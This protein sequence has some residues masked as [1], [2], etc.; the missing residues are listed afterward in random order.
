MISVCGATLGPIAL[1]MAQD[2]FGSYNPM[3]LALALIPV[4]LAVVMALFL[5]DPKP[6]Q[7]TAKYTSTRPPN[8][9]NR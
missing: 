1:G 7:R 6:P 2:W 3:L 9:P 5:S 4:C 8:R